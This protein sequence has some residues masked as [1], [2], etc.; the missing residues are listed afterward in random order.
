MATVA[1]RREKKLCPRKKP[2]TNYEP[3]IPLTPTGL[4]MEGHFTLE[5][6]ESLK[7]VQ[8]SKRPSRSGRIESR[9]LKQCLCMTE[10]HLPFSAS[11][12]NGYSTRICGRRVDLQSAEA[13]R[14]P[15]QLRWYGLLFHT[16]D[17]KCRNQAITLRTPVP[18]ILRVMAIFQQLPAKV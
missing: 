11:S 8:G 7:S 16:L 4:L 3:R 13:A 2:G 6:N 15:L 12:L 17:H 18:C 5:P 9:S 14:P 1:T 10:P